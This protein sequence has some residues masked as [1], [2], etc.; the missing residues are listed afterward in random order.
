M[1]D[2]IQKCVTKRRTL[3]TFNTFTGQSEQAGI[4][5]FE[6]FTNREKGVV[7]SMKRIIYPENP[8]FLKIIFYTVSIIYL[9]EGK[10]LKTTKLF[11]HHKVDLQWLMVLIIDFLFVFL[12]IDQ[13]FPWLRRNLCGST[14]AT[15]VVRICEFLVLLFFYVLKGGTY[16]V[17]NG[18]RFILVKLF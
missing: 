5:G 17:R 18:G 16:S 10:I 15:S 2:H 8:H 4:E 11:L 3:G 9:W 12:L 6:N 13:Q 7:Y 1:C 14:P